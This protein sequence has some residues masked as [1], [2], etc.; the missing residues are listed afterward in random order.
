MKKGGKQCRLM[1]FSSISFSFCL[2][3]ACALS[4]L[5]S[6]FT[7]SSVSAS[8]YIAGDATEYWIGFTNA[9]SSSNSD[10]I[11]DTNWSS[12]NTTRS[13]FSSS[14]NFSPTNLSF[15]AP[16]SVSSNMI[17]SDGSISISGAVRLGVYLTSPNNRIFAKLPSSYQ[18]FTG[19]NF[20]FG[21]TGSKGVFNL[22][23]RVTSTTCTPSSG[24]SSAD[25]WDS[26]ITTCT[27]NFTATGSGFTTGTY[28][29]NWRLN[30]NSIT[31]NTKS[32]QWS[33]VYG[34][35]ASVSWSVR[36]YEA[37]Y[38]LDFTTG[39][40]GGNTGGGTSTDR[41]YTAALDQLSSQNNT[42]IGQNNQIISGI[43]NLGDTI[44]NGNQ[45]VINTI[46]NQSKQEQDRY[47]K[48]KQEEADR[49]DSGKEDADKAQ[50]IFNFNILNPFAPLF[51]MF[52]PS[53]CVQIPTLSDW[54]HTEDTQVCPWF[55][56]KVRQI[57]TPVLSIASVMLLFGFVVG[58]LNG[59]DVDGTIKV[60]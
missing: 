34:V 40:T 26:A 6:A 39:S 18:L 50:A 43:D 1:K 30:G 3:L 23:P 25:L 54:L 51:E 48:D 22:S 13:N 14:A 15:T 46:N 10:Y 49:E 7:S 29:L 17:N 60:K 52:N 42:M 31:N 37:Y 12:A 35:K 41:D 16:I 33:G 27:V 19:N 20:N 28:Y 55:P 44:T 21:L 53:G 24:P 59:N 4:F 58:W 38:A 2:V 45:Q 9:N 32:P 8:S 36:G 11:Y 57:A 56:V 47:D 5:C